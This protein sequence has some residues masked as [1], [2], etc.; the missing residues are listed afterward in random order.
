[1]VAVLSANTCFSLRVQPA[2]Q[3][4][5][6]HKQ[7]QKVQPHKKIKDTTRRVAWSTYPQQLRT[8]NTSASLVCPSTAW[9]AHAV[10]MMNESSFDDATLFH[11]PPS[12]VG[13]H[14]P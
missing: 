2:L 1:M 12:M 9:V 11:T 4:T 14:R 6:K 10:R 5:E 7:K 3:R 8:L 13:Q